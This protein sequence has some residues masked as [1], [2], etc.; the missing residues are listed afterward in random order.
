MYICTLPAVNKYVWFIVMHSDVFVCMHSI[1]TF[2]CIAYGSVI[3][4]CECIVSAGGKKC[5][6]RP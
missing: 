2:G 1:W 5:L 4:M 6:I 3:R